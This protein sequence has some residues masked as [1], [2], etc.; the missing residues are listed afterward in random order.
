MDWEFC[1]ATGLA[2]GCGDNW[3][4]ARRGGRALEGRRDRGGWRKRG[5]AGGIAAL[6][7]NTLKP[8]SALLN[9]FNLAAPRFIFHLPSASL[10]PTP[11]R[12]RWEDGVCG[13]GS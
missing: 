3:G 10:A 4:L 11:K 6:A 9:A 12:L 8:V 1:V 7:K 13:S 5:R 2:K